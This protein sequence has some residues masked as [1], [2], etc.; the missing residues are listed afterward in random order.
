MASREKSHGSFFAVSYH[1]AE[2][3]IWRL[4]QIALHVDVSIKGIALYAKTL[5][6]Q[7][8]WIFS[9]QKRNACFHL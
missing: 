2:I 1:A 3:Y 8:N 5:V 9:L 7:E 6:F 4:G